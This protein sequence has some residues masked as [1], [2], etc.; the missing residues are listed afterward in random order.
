MKVEIKLYANLARYLPPNVK[1]AGGIMDVTDGLTIEGLM[2]QLRVPED[3]VK[4]IFVDGIH[5]DRKTILQ[6]GCRLG[7]FPPVGGG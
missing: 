4:L 1:E 2:H 7:I 6:E 5:A 3:Q